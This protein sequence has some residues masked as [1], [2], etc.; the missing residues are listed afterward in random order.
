[1]NHL[2]SACLVLAIFVAFS[3]SAH[4]NVGSG[5]TAIAY[6]EYAANCNPASAQ[7]DL[8]INNVRTT[9]LN[10]GDMWWNLNDA[11]YEVPKVDP[12][13]GAPS[14]H[15]LFA[16]AI[17]VGGI[18]AGGQLKIACQTY[19]QN[20]NDFW[21]GPLDANASVNS[22][23]CDDYNKFWKVKGT[24]IDSLLGAINDDPDGCIDK[25]SVPK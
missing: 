8:D 3:T 10:G 6:K 24:D 17:W 14:V 23:T 15:A 11:R 2:K 13:S 4:E 22:G 25:S 9:L 19:R 20:G 5:K 7:I 21:P 18:D 1:M 12:S 16:G